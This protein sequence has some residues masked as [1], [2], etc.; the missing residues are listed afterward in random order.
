MGKGS[1]LGLATVYAIIKE[2]DGWVEVKSHPGA[3][4]TFNI[5]FP[6]A[7]AARETVSQASE[8]P[9]SVTVKGQKETILLVEDEPVLREWVKEVLQTNSYQVLE[10][11]TG[12]EALN[13]WDG[14]A[15]KIDLLLT[16]MVMPEGMT[17][18]ELAK[19]LRSR[20]PKLKVIYTSGFSSDVA[21]NDP[22]LRGIPF[23]SKPFPAPQ[24]T[25]LVRSCLD[26]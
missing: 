9:E 16:D 12:Q 24:L 18:R 22:E 10:A 15:G 23:L 11:S 25:Q 14:Q 13:V 20:E 1:G 4:T 7:A 5:F 26:A 2:H 6:A 21:A 3:G 17:G 19:Q 8:A